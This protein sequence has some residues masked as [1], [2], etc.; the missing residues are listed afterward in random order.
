MVTKASQRRGLARVSRLEVTCRFWSGRLVPGKAPGGR[1]ILGLRPLHGLPPLL[2][3][4][5]LLA[6]PLDGGLL[7]VGP[8]LHLLEEAVLQHA[9]LQGLQGRLDLVVV[10]FHPH[11]PTLLVPFP[12]V[13]REHGRNMAG[14][15]SAGAVGLAACSWD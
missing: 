2:A 3:R 6:L 10:D 15:R 13:N 9:L 7:V 12:G 14:T 5:G 1:L 8:L 11:D 4:L